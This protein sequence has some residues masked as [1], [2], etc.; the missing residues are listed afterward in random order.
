MD[1]EKLIEVVDSTFAAA[2]MV[3]LW[4]K[5]DAATAFDEVSVKDLR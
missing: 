1:G 4:T 3:G 5:A 2:G